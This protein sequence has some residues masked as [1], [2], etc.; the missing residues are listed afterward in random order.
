MRCGVLSPHSSTDT[1]GARQPCGGRG[2]VPLPPELDTAETWCSPSLARPAGRP[3]VVCPAYCWSVEQLLWKTAFIEQGTDCSVPSFN[4]LLI[5]S[6]FHSAEERWWRLWRGFSIRR[7]VPPCEGVCSR[8]SR[9]AN[10]WFPPRPPSPPLCSWKELT[11]FVAANGPSTGAGGQRSARGS[12]PCGS[13]CLSSDL[14]TYNAGHRQH[15][16][17]YPL[18]LPNVNMFVDLE[19]K[20]TAST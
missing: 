18:L 12:A 2:S 15:T 4:L 14:M 1:L 13:S 6:H 10:A 5:L 17:G 7:A 9:C 11:H 16:L 8:S 19:N 3:E 20:Q